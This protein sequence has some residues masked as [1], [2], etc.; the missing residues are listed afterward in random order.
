MDA[1][2]ATLA[3]GMPAFLLIL[4]RLSG[5]FLAAPFWSSRMFP[6]SVKVSLCLFLA[7]TL[8]P[9]VDVSRAPDAVLPLALAAVGELAWGAL[10]GFAASLCFA[11]VQLAGYYLDFE[12][13]MGI[14]NVVDPTFGAPVPLA[15]TFLY[16]LALVV[17]L[18]ADGH[19]L[20]LSALVQSF[21]AIPPGAVAIPGA[22]GGGLVAQAGAMFVVGPEL[23]A[24]VVVPLFLANLALGLVSRTVPQLNVLVVGL[25]LKSWLGVL[26]L[27]MALPAY[28]TA[29]GRW[30]ERVAQA[31]LRVVV[32]GGGGGP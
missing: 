32:P 5:L 19:H 9:A 31:L 18:S 12:L 23:A 20:L 29:F 25:P 10:A 30:H 21:R 28:V 13:G 8:L 27:G 14:A 4:M 3:A 26:F 17:F 7:L 16:L 15:G 22:A 2:L 1:L 6:V 11:A 24:P